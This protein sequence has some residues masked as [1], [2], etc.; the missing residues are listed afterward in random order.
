MLRYHVTISASSNLNS[1][2]LHA[3]IYS[4]LGFVNI[5]LYMSNLKINCRGHIK[6][7]GGAQQ[8]LVDERMDSENQLEDMI[9]LEEIVSMGK[10]RC[11]WQWDQLAG[12]GA[13][14]FRM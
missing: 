4:G 3:I 7:E 5:K 11:I 2:H 1:H 6:V 14:S 8:K 13:V 12:V 10:Q 9:R